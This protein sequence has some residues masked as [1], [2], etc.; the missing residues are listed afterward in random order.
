MSPLPGCDKER[1]NC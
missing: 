1:L